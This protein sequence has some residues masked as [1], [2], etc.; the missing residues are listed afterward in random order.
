MKKWKSISSIW[1]TPNQNFAAALKQRFRCCSAWRSAVTVL[2]LLR[3]REK[4]S[5][6]STIFLSRSVCYSHFS[7]LVTVVVVISV[8]PFSS[9]HAA[10]I[11]TNAVEAMKT[12][13]VLKMLLML[14]VCSIV[15]VIAT[16]SDDQPALS[17][18]CSDGKVMWLFINVKFWVANVSNIKSIP[19]WAMGFLSTLCPNKRPWAFWDVVNNCVK[20]K[21][22]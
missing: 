21:F 18:D 22:S 11:V 16:T 9:V 12:C 14:M 5:P 10:V 8:L 1:S 13:F 15:V 6:G 4:S 7:L 19:P 2:Q 17:V 20:L 3:C